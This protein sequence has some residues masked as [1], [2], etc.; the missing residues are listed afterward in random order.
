M[1]KDLYVTRWQ[2]SAVKAAIKATLIHKKFMKLL[3]NSNITEGELSEI[4][5]EAVNRE[6]VKAILNSINLNRWNQP[7]N[8]QNT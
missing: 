5:T 2:K 4:L 8:D 7:T 1:E 6:D 3:S